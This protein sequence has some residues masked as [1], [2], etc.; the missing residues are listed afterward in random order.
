MV[1][2]AVLAGAGSRHSVGSSENWQLAAGHYQASVFAL[3]LI[4]P[5]MQAERTADGGGTVPSWAYHML[6]PTG[7]TRYIRLGVRGGS[8]PWYFD[9]TSTDLVGCTIENDSDL[10]SYGT[11]TIPPQS[12]AT[13]SITVRARD[14]AGASISKT[15]APVVRAVTDTTYFIHLTDGSGGT[16]VGTPT[17]PFRQLGD[18]IG[19]NEDDAT[20]QGKQVIVSGTHVI[21]GHSAEYNASGEALFMNSNK[22]QVWVAVTPLGATWQGSADNGD[23]ALF[24][25]QGGT[26][27]AWVGF[28]WE[29]PHHL[30]GGINHRNGY[31]GGSA[32]GYFADNDVDLAST[33]DSTNGN[34]SAAI[35]ASNGSGVHHMAIMGNRFH[36]GTIEHP[37]LE[38]YDANDI[39]WGMNELSN[40]SGTQ[41]VYV[42]GGDSQDRWFYCFNFGTGNSGTLH[43]IDMIDFDGPGAF[44]REDHEFMHNRYQTSGVGLRVK[45]TSDVGSTF[46]MS[47]YSKRDNWK[48]ANHYF[49]GSNALDTA[50]FD[51]TYCV[52]EHSGTY[53]QG[54]RDDGGYTPDLT[55][56]DHGTSGLL[57]DTTAAQ[58]SPDGTTGREVL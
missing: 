17:N 58:D 18:I 51:M 20:H 14:Q 53:T 25:M 9:I 3:E 45:G 32:Y 48:V 15:W 50:V 57:N 16:E 11:L 33:A 1:A 38:F 40:Y 36:D 47:V 44:T 54:V 8:P 10:Q 4:Y 35:I 5:R 13:Y 39:L 7:H 41:G 49:S 12:A 21:V 24:S 37:P 31:L 30:V 56:N 29:N 2:L 34:N 43:T 22:P 19:P 6:L 27:W 55:G 26:D 23:G 42:K 52:I 28:N 46:S